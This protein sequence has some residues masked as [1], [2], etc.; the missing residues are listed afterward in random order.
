MIYVM[1]LIL[2][3]LIIACGHRKPEKKTLLGQLDTREPADYDKIIGE[4]GKPKPQ[5][6]NGANR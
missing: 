1:F 3:L 2:C 4:Y 5:D 6:K